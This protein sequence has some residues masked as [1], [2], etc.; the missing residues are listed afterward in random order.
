MD[1]EA[2]VLEI[3]DQQ[4]SA[5]CIVIDDENRIGIFMRLSAIG[6]RLP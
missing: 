5:V 3:L 2:L 1:R 4:L 6:C